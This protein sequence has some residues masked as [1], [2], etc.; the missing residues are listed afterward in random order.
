M[1]ANEG[2]GAAEGGSGVMSAKWILFGGGG[3]GQ[4]GGVWMMDC[5]LDT[6]A[7]EAAD[8]LEC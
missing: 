5:G 2:V 1:S 6:G 3:F 4:V 7:G 8:N